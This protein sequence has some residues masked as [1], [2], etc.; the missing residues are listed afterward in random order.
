MQDF[1]NVGE[2]KLCQRLLPAPLRDQLALGRIQVGVKSAR[3]LANDKHEEPK[4]SRKIRRDLR[5][6]FPTH[7]ETSMRLL[8]LI[9]H[10]ID[11]A[12]GADSRGPAREGT[13]DL[14]ADF[15]PACDV[16]R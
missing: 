15:H 16:A 3:R 5:V 1:A 6:D 4:G 10:S 2:F 7:D 14:D 12:R 8:S 11:K 9:N 13:K